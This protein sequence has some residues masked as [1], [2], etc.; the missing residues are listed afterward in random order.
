MEAV[1]RGRIA[2]LGA[3]TAAVMAGFV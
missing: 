1:V 2:A 3:V